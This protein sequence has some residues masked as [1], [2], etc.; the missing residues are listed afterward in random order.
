MSA[1][2]FAAGPAV[3][4]RDEIERVRNID[5]APTILALLDVAPAATVQGRAIDL[6]RRGHGHRDRDDD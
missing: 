5:I 6:C 1:I 3:C 4:G 2:F